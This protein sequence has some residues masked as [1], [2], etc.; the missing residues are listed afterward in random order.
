[1]AVAFCKIKKISPSFLLHPLDLVGG[2][3][4][5]ELKFFP[6]MNLKSELKT[7]IFI[8]VITLLSRNYELVNMNRHAY[9]YKTSKLN[10]A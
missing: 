10:T 6:G 4:I 8:D 7:K 5:P 2:D 9:S 1:M 3:L